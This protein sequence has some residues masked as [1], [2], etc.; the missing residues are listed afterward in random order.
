MNTLNKDKTKNITNDTTFAAQL[1][2]SI[3]IID[4]ANAMMAQ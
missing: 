1:E 3:N 2:N 4:E